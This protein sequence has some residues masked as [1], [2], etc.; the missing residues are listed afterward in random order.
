MFI[1]EAIIGD[2]E[3]QLHLDMKYTEGEKSQSSREA[4]LCKTR[5]LREVIEHVYAYSR[6]NKP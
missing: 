6:S 1:Y 3:P 2:V 5:L 4:Q